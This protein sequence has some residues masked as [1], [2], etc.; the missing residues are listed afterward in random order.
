MNEIHVRGEVKDWEIWVRGK[1][2]RLENV[3]MGGS[4]LQILE[5][6]CLSVSFAHFLAIQIG[7][8]EGDK[9]LSPSESW[10]LGLHCLSW[11][12]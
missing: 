4:D 2:I 12:G 9:T 6:G 10:Y 11:C 8:G 7:G 3:A 5:R 1:E